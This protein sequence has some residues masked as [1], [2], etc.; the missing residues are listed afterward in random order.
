MLSTHIWQEYMDIVEQLRNIHRLL[1]YGTSA[2][3]GRSVMPGEYRKQPDK[4]GVAPAE[5]HKRMDQLLKEYELRVVTLEQILEFHVRF[6]RIRPFDDYNGRVGRVIMLKV[7]HPLS[8]MISV[9]VPTTAVSPS[10][11]RTS[12]F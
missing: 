11:I 12:S 8:L 5:I 9:V 7:C 1:T 3:H 6:E 4:I 2:D 10:G